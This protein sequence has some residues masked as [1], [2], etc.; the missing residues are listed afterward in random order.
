MKNKIREDNF[1]SIK[2]GQKSYIIM[3]KFRVRNEVK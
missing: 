3:R 2:T 1:N